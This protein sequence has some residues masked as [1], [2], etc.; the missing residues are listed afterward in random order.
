MVVNEEQARVVRMIFRMFLQGHTPQTISNKLTEAGCLTPAG[1][2][3]WNQTTVRRMLSNEKYKGDALL[4][5]DF[6]VDF[7]RKKVKKNCG[8]LPQ[9]YVE[10]DHEAII[11]PWLFDYVQE[12]VAARMD[13]DN[14]KRRGRYSGVYQ[15][16]SKI[17]CAKCGRQFGIKPFHSTTYNNL[18]WQC[19]NRYNKKV[20]CKTINIYDAYLHVITHTAAM[21]R[22]RRQPK[23]VR[24]LMDCVQMVVGDE[25][26]EEIHTAIK[27]MQRET[28]WKLWSDEDDL[29]LIIGHLGVH[30]DGRVVVYWLDGKETEYQTETFRPTQYFSEKEERPPAAKKPVKK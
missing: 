21:E 16:S 17:I 28:V 6:T 27:S 14:A 4:Q 25:R 9:Y 3:T 23:V 13:A 5:K 11:A 24:D 12:I 1:L 15:Y 20:N 26:S 18:V 2:E 22:I 8:E 7:L 10:G 29:S 30:A 19:R